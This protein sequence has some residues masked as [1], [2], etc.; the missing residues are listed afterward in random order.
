MRLMKIK[1]PRSVW[2]SFQ[3]PL[4]FSKIPWNQHLYWKC[5]TEKSSLSHSRNFHKRW[6]DFY[7]IWIVNQYLR[8]R[9]IETQ[10]NS[11]NYVHSHVKA[12]KFV[13][14]RPPLKHFQSKVQIENDVKHDDDKNPPCQSWPRLFKCRMNENWQVEHE[15]FFR[16]MVIFSSFLK[17]H[18]RTTI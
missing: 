3:K 16:K 14:I 4:F 7:Q 11:Q 9:I 12:P 15:I 13:K 18:Q 6:A 2:K 10:S 5:K 1:Y 8:I 17:S